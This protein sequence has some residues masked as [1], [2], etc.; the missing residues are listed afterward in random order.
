MSNKSDYQ[1]CE[2]RYRV[3]FWVSHERSQTGRMMPVFPPYEY[4]IE[5]SAEDMI[6][7]RDTAYIILNQRGLDGGI[8]D[9]ERLD[10]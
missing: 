3:T 1:R 7:A 10:V 8:R 6:E 4:E 2:G 5:V 9:H